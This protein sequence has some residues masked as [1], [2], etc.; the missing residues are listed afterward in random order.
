M[1]AATP[2]ANNVNI[3]VNSVILNYMALHGE[4]GQFGDL[5]YPNWNHGLGS[6]AQLDAL[7]A[8]EPIVNGII[9]NPT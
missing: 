6:G 3:L 7:T 2:M 5:L 9:A 4:Q 1:R 8:F